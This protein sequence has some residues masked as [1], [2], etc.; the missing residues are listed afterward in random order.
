MEYKFRPNDGRPAKTV[1]S[2]EDI[3]AYMG[4]VLD[5]FDNVVIHDNLVLAYLQGQGVCIGKIEQ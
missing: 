4:N 5:E 1:S 3:R 2:T